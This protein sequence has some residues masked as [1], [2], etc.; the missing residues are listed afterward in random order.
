LA[1]PLRPQLPNFLNPPATADAAVPTVPGVSQPS[2]Q[3]P[4]S[5]KYRDANWY[6]QQR[7]KQPTRQQTAD[8]Q[9]W[10]DWIRKAYGLAP[11]GTDAAKMGLENMV[12]NYRS[13]TSPDLSQQ[14]IN[15]AK[16]Q[17]YLEMWS[18]GKTSNVA[19]QYPLLSGLL[20]P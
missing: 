7:A 17:P 18:R 19:D 11:T 2:I 13:G 20:N 15:W 8:T 10:P 5:Q 3:S 4:A 1:I 14:A 6:R 16:Q 9:N 12:S